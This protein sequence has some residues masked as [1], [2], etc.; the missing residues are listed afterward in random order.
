MD[1][2]RIPTRRQRQVLDALQSFIERFGYSPSLEELAAAVG[3]SSV[4]TIHKHLKNLEAAGWVR[5]DRHRG[6]TV[7]PVEMVRAAAVETP[8]L[9]L[10]AAGQPIEASEVHETV[11][12]P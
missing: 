8:L 1:G 7:T 9:G 2:R 3:L 11:T 12:L 4:A 10:I 6:R 5:R